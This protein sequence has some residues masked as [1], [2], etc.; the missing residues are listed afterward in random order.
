LALESFGKFEQ[1]I[2]REST[3]VCFTLL[4]KVCWWYHYHHYSYFF[5]SV[6]IIIIM[7]SHVID[8]I[9]R[10]IV[11]IPMQFLVQSILQ[12]A[13]LIIGNHNYMI[14]VISEQYTWEKTTRK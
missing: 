8:K 5:I 10:N 9:I 7:S 11:T 13:T 3:K 1:E 12:T 2:H 6:I 4:L 14:L